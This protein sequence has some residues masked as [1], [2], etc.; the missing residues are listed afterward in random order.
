[1]TSA[2]KQKIESKLQNELA[3]LDAAVVSTVPGLETCP[4]DTD[5]A[6]QL[7]QHELNL[8]LIRRA[9]ENRREI[10]HALNRLASPEYGECLECGDHIGDARLLANPLASLCVDCQEKRENGLCA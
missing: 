10:E 6:S 4:D 5:F 8:T 9:S 7:T 3:G 1:M 2:L